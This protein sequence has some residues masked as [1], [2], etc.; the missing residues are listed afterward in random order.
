MSEG[1]KGW[2]A[3]GGWADRATRWIAFIG[4]VGLLIITGFILVDIVMRAL[5]NSPI[6]GL[7]DIG[8]FTFGVAVAACFPAGLIQ[9]HNVA[10][11]F[12]G[13]AVGPKRATWLELFSALCTLV[14]FFLI[15]WRLVLFT[16]D[17]IAHHRYTPTL[18]ISTGP[19]WSLITGMICLTVPVQILVLA[20]WFKRLR[21]GEPPPSIDIGRELC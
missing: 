2:I 10:I 13:K 5:F 6:D 1:T 9:G 8:K 18:Q 15:A 11:R 3:P 20:L 7:E 19:F 4:L 14:F 21:H 16:L 12:L 17:E